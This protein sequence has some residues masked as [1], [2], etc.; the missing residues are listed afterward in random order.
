MLPKDNYADETYALHKLLAHESFRFIIV[1]HNHYSFVS[2]LI[3][4]ISTRYSNRE[5][6]QINCRTAD[7]ESILADYEAQEGG[8]FILNNFEDV[9]Q[10]EKDSQGNESHLMAEAN[11]RRKGIAI[12]LNLRR[13]RLAKRKIALIL[14]IGPFGL[15][16]RAI[17]LMEFMPDL[18]SF[19]SLILDLH[20]EATPNEEFVF[21][22]NRSI[23]PNISTLGGNTA[24]EKRASL[25]ALKLRFKELPE[26]ETGL[27]LRILDEIITLLRELNEFDELESVILQ[28]NNLAHLPTQDMMQ[29]DFWE[30]VNAQKQ[31]QLS[32]NPDLLLSKLEQ[33]SEDELQLLR[34]FSVLPERP[35]RY[36]LLVDLLP[37]NHPKALLTLITNGWLKVETESKSLSIAADVQA[38]VLNGSAKPIVEDVNSLCDKLI[39]KLHYESTTGNFLNITKD[40]VINYLEIAVSILSK[41]NHIADEIVLLNERVGNAFSTFGEYQ[42][43]L[44]YFEEFNRLSGEMHNS[45]PEN[46]NYRRYLVHSVDKL[47]LTYQALGK[48]EKALYYFER[49]H[50]LSQ[51]LH[52]EFPE[53]IDFK[54][55]LTFS[56]DRLG[57]ILDE[58]GEYQKALEYFKQYNRYSIELYQAFPDNINFKNLMAL[59]YRKLGKTLEALGE[60]EKALENFKEFN[61]LYKELILAF[62]E[63]KVFKSF[64]AISLDQLGDLFLKLDKFPMALVFFE[65]LNQVS[66]KYVQDYPENI[67]F[68]LG[69]AI[70]F[71]KLGDLHFALGNFQKAFDYFN[72]LNQVATELSQH[73]PDNITSRKGLSVSYSKLYKVLDKLGK[74]EEAKEYLIKCH[75]TLSQLVEQF[76]EV[77]EYRENL[78]K[79]ETALKSY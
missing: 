59:S 76:P 15:K 41:A 3:E 66:I 24:I 49:F 33:L 50:L 62:P 16:Q 65:E 63:N 71:G 10:L 48:L 28:R 5:L 64:F 11:E 73:F 79:V 57:S 7:Y 69:L 52:L 54:V 72:R 14:M 38:I 51:E 1:F 18:W 77:M 45:L 44:E 53:N 22:S 61:R 30:S 13:D 29:T 46:I 20:R 40:V 42:K 74:T 75:T 34:I 19:R 67:D 56:F 36:E 70:S 35:I 37:I 32:S 8:F 55:R 68:R 25:N 4:D 39:E 9:L 21:H 60:L 31:V 27:K 26:Q 12:G 58:I 43:A 23:L 47:G 78:E 17:P 2:R 6:K